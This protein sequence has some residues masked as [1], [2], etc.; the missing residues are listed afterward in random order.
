MNISHSMFM[1]LVFPA[2]KTRH[3]TECGPASYY[4]MILQQIQAQEL[5]IRLQSKLQTLWSTTEILGAVHLVVSGARA[6]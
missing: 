3:L 1:K 5:S 6:L 4:Y 2:N